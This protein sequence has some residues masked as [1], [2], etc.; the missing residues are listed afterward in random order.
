MLD[1]LT[2]LKNLGTSLLGP[3]SGAVVKYSPLKELHHHHEANA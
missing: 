2:A 1:F 3:Q